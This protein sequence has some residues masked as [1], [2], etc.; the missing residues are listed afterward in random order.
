MEVETLKNILK[1][2]GPRS[3]AGVTL[4]LRGGAKI[5]GAIYGPHENTVR[6]EHESD[7]AECS[8]IVVDAI[9]AVQFL[10]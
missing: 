2:F 10:T 4:Y 7:G 9:D 1:A 3:S 8:Y 5:T 6:I